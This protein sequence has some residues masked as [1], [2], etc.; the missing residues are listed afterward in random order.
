MTVHYAA[1]GHISSGYTSERV[2]THGTIVPSKLKLR[3]RGHKCENWGT[4]TLQGGGRRSGS[5]KQELCAPSLAREGKQHPA[6]LARGRVLGVR[7]RVEGLVDQLVV[8]LEED[9]VVTDAL[10]GLAPEPSFSIT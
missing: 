6:V 5:L 2:R 9:A 7:L 3:P 8:R 10:V 4:R 1:T